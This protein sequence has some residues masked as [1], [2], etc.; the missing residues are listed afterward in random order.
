MKGKNK[1]KATKLFLAVILISLAIFGWHQYSR[2]LPAI[3][4]VKIPVAETVKQTDVNLVWPKYGQAAV[5]A[6]DFG[7]LQTHGQQKPVP[8]ASIAK[9]ITALAVLQKRPLSENQQ[10]PTIKITSSDVAI[11]N[12]YYKKDGSVA[13]VEAGESI[14][15]YQALQAMLLPSANNFADTLAIWAF[16]SIENYNDYANTYVKQLGMNDT[17]VVD[18]SGFSPKT[19]STAKDLIILGSKALSNPVL[20]EIV[21]QDSAK[22]PVAGKITNV[23]WLLGERGVNGIK[24]GN[25]RE[26]GGCFLASAKQTF[27]G[28]D[29]EVISAVISAPN[30]NQAITDSGLL[31]SSMSGGFVNKVGIKDKQVIGYYNVPWAGSVKAVARSNISILSWKGKGGEIISRLNSAA[32]G[33]VKGSITGSVTYAVGEKK[34]STPVVLSQNIAEPSWLWRIFG[35]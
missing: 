35:R 5:G 12:D 17:K 8:I 2:P 3:Q 1:A 18:A 34:S 33:Q 10:G 7:V 20:S 31:V 13:R 30:V 6:I 16:G 4:A 26:A 21:S 11:Y 29:I 28:K 24:T 22:I 14:S 23:N 32:A 19:L 27:D 25:T 15:Q 9:V